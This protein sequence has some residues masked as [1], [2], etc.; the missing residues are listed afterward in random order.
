MLARSFR[1]NP[2]NCA[3][4]DNVP[5]ARLRANYYG[6]RNLLETATG[7]ALCW[8]LQDGSYRSDLRASGVGGV[9]VAAPPGGYPLPAPAGF[10]RQLQLIWGQGFRVLGRWATVFHA[11]EE[12]HPVDPHWYLALLGIDPD[13]QGA[14]LGTALLRRF[15][16]RVDEDAV[17]AYLE[18]DRAENVAFYGQVGF[19]VVREVEVLGVHVWCMQRP[20]S[21]R[22]RDLPR[23]VT[24][25]S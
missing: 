24:V 22:P 10:R 1:D 21:V 18:T 11:L 2:L 20:A 12:V 7:V 4:V 15:A 6:M 3:V 9:L 13:L 19:D 17:P 8:C 14:G 5:R 23:K 25:D 16:D